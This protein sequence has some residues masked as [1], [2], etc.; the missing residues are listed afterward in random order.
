MATY[1]TSRTPVRY[2]VLF[3]GSV[4]VV[5]LAGTFAAPA[6]AADDCTASGLARTISGVA[7]NTADYLEA[8]P[9]VNDA[10]TRLKGESRPQMRTDAQQYLNANPQVRADWQRLRAPLNDLAQRCGVAFPAG[11]LGG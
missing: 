1:S 3:G 11:P 2:R 4:I 10:F 7:A 9:D 6:A 5:V 8:H